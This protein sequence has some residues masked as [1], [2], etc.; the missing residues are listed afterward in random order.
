M[1]RGA[2]HLHKFYISLDIETLQGIEVTYAQNG[3]NVLI[4]TEADMDYNSVDECITLHLS[5][6]DTLKF[7]PV[8]IPAT[9]KDSLITIQFK[10]FDVH[11]DVFVSQPI[12]ERLYDVLHDEVMS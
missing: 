6:E 4:K 11:G 7:A 5:Q 8:G 3:H 9:V 10:F 1:I 2:S 12:R